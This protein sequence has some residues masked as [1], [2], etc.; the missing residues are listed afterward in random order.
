L[1]QTGGLSLASGTQGP[2]LHFHGESRGFSYLFQILFYFLLNV[3]GEGAHEVQ[4]LV[5]SL[6]SLRGL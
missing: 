6:F 4:I 5:N 3:D 1:L 2:L